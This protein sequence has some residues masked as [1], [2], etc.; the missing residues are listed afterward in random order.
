MD[1][2]HKFLDLYITWLG[3]RLYDNGRAIFF[4]YFQFMAFGS[5]S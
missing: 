1:Q 5:G 2:T 3:Y 4:E